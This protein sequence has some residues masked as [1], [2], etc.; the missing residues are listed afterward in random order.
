MA[1]SPNLPEPPG[2]EGD[3]GGGA[4]RGDGRVRWRKFALLTVPAIAVT[5][6]SE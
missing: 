5:R 4:G 1:V 6:D 3:D 2:T